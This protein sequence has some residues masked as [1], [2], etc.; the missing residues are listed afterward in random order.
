MRNKKILAIDF[1]GTIVEDKYPHIG[2]LKDGAKYYI[3]KF[4]EDGYKVILWSSRNGIPLLKA[5]EFLTKEGITFDEYNNSCRE[6]VAKYGEDTRKIFADVYIDDKCIKMRPFPDWK[7][8]YNLVH[9]WC[10]P[11]YGDLVGRD[12]QL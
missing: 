3:N 11:N 8:I 4:K 6:N 1:D 10:P 9:T 12:G 2:E 5:I 7:E